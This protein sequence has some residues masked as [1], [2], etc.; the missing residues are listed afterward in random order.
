MKALYYLALVCFVAVACD[1]GKDDYRPAPFLYEDDIRPILECM[2]M[3]RPSDSYNYPVYPGMEEWKNLNTHEKKLNACQ[4]PISVLK[5]MS[6]QAVIQAI[7]E[8]P[9]LFLILSLGFECQLEFENLLSENNAYIEL[10]GREDAGS[11]LLTRL[12]LVDPLYP[13]IGAMLRSQILEILVSQPVFL[14]QLDD[15][16]KKE[17]VGI[18]L[19]NDDLRDKA[20]I[21]GM[22]FYKNMAWLLMGRVMIAAGFAPFVDAVNNDNRLK[23][24]LETADQVFPDFGD[25]GQRI[26][27][28]AVQYLDEN[29]KT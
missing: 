6:T 16:S 8:H 23:D 7:W 1:N 14:A 28:Y 9:L 20:G 5:K 24:F 4:V 15:L 18:T 26:I 2:N 25:R 27:D 11:A 19:K 22:S 3:D 17:V 10:A 13:D 21:G 12:A 29:G